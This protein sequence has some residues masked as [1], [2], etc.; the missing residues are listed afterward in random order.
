MTSPILGALLCACLAPL[1]PVTADVV[2]TVSVVANAELT[3][4]VLARVSEDTG[5]IILAD[6]FVARRRMTVDL[7]D[8]PLPEA[9]DQLSAASVATWDSAYILVPTDAGHGPEDTPPCWARP[10]QC[11]LSLS[12]GTGSA[13]MVTRAITNK[14]AAPMG[15]APALAEATI[16]TKPAEDASLEDV[17]AAVGDG[18]YTWTRGFWFAPIDRAAVFGRYA[19]L[20]MDVRE[21]RVLRHTDQMLRLDKEAV[22]Q[23][24]F[25]RHRDFSALSPAD[26]EAEIDMYA[27]QIRTGIAVLNS[28]GSE[29]R[30]RAR[31]GM[32][33]FF[34]MG[35]EVYRDLTEDE[36]IEATPIIEAMGELE[37]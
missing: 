12:G 14:C 21:E 1:P 9:L 18:G 20:P 37:R 2:P 31:E 35:L 29:V 10:P 25:D 4:D 15:Y 7:K 26:R 23:A 30:D 33:V 27:E 28:L 36:Q 5:L 17:L 24:L 3:S 8:V 22:R 6:P 11:S 13:D 32:R 16:A 19:S 34:D